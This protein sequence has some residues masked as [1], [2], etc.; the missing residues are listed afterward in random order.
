MH[1]SLR[2]LSILTML[3]AAC[4]GAT[5]SDDVAAPPEPVMRPL[6]PLAAQRVILTPAFSLVAPDPL[7]WSA[8]LPKS[9]EYLRQLDDTLQS[10]LSERGLKSQWIYPPDLVRAMKGSPTYAV[11]PYALGAGMLRSHAV[12]SGTRLGDPLATQLRTMIAL[13]ED[14]RAVLVPVELHFEKEKT[15]QGFAVLRV[16]LLDARIGDVRWVGNVR[17][18]PVDK[19]SP[20]MLA[21]LAG[22]LADLITS[23]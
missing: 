7:G 19:P 18:E 9:R 8:Q 16:A 22:H 4:H 6:A 23:P 21:S 13:Q 1:R 12:V 2:Q 11:D 15:G 10:V 14:A 5:K 17:S 20:A 3:L